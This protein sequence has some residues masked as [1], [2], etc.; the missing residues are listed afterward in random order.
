MVTAP[1]D[2]KMIENSSYAATLNTR[3]Q[4]TGWPWK[5]LPFHSICF[6]LALESQPNFPSS[7]VYIILLYYFYFAPFLL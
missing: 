4:N 7:Q 1:T 5:A 2:L 6:I 3:K